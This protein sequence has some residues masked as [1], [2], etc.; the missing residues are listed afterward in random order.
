MIRV[1]KSGQTMTQ[2]YVRSL[3]P[4]LINKPLSIVCLCVCFASY[5][6]SAILKKR[7]AYIRVCWRLT[8]VDKQAYP[9]VYVQ[10]DPAHVE[11]QLVFRC[12]HERQVVAVLL[13]CITL[14]HPRLGIWI[15]AAARPFLKNF[16]RER[17]FFSDGT[18]T[19]TLINTSWTVISRRVLDEFSSCKWFF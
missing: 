4:K 11:K 13:A 8:D 1:S 15:A 2:I 16:R 12:V 10:L 7:R 3:T 5:Y 6:S 17:A 14:T 9:S 19:C 18:R